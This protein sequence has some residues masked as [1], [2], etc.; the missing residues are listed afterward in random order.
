M[1]AKAVLAKPS[2]KSP[3]DFHKSH[4]QNVIVPERF[5]TGI[6]NLGPKGWM[7]LGDFM[8]ENKINPAQGTAYREQFKDC[9][10]E[11]DKKMIICGS[12]KLADEFRE[13]I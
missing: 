3:T 8:R 13:A 2:V 12:K 11:A 9:I 6:K 1:A 5:R 10:L 4:N 7:Y